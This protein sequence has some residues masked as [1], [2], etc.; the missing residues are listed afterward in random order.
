MTETTPIKT[1]EQYNRIIMSIDR[2][3]NLDYFSIYASA[4]D[5]LITLLRESVQEQ[6]VDAQA[7]Y[8]EAYGWDES[9]E[10]FDQ[11]LDSEFPLLA[12]LPTWIFSRIVED[13]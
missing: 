5:G 4:L 10:P 8:E 12:D 9:P 3:L 6:Y 2:G 1:E 13:A 7:M 11:W